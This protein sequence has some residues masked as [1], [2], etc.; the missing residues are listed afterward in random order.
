MPKHLRLSKKGF[1]Y[2][3]ANQIYKKTKWVPPSHTGLYDI[4]YVP[5]CRVILNVDIRL[6]R[7]C[8]MT[9]FYVSRILSF[10]NCC[11]EDLGE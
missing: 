4:Y 5:L 11:M 2:S 10:I 7:L 8:W 6:S 9:N 3:V 1:G